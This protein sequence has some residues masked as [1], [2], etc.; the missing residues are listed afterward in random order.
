MAKLILG[1]NTRINVQ[2]EKVIN[3]GNYNSERVHLGI[4]TDLPDDT[5]LMKAVA[6]HDI[7]WGELNQLGEDIR[8]DIMGKERKE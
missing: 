7:I 3:T 1:K 2:I 6:T 5:P 4:E 8:N